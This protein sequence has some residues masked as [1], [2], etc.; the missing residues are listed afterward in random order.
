MIRLEAD[1]QW[2]YVQNKRNPRW[3]WWV[4]DHDTGEVV[5]FLFGP[6]R[7]C[8]RTNESF[9]RLLTLLTQSGIVVSRWFTDY[10]WAYYDL[11]PTAIH[12]AGKDQTQSI[13]RKHLDLRTRIKRLA[14]R[15]ICFSKSIL[16]HDTVIGLLINHLFFKL[17]VHA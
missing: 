8:G 6:V 14:R 15:T 4:E 17:D 11:L 13:E 5:A 16:M 9:S 12:R 2:S 1:E 10:W 7:R 3:L